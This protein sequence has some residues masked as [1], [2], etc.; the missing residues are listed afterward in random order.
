MRMSMGRIA[1]MTIR[2]LYLAR[3]SLDHWAELIYWPVIDLLLWGLTTRWIESEHGDVPLFALIV[4]TGVVFW[5]IVWRASHEI[6][7]NLLQ[8][9]WSQ[10]LLNLFATPLSVWE[11]SASLVVLGLFKN[12]LTMIVGIATV[13]LLYRLNILVVGWMLLPFFFSLMASGW[14]VGFI[15]AGLIIYYGRRLQGLAWILGF[16]LAPF[17]AVYY[18]VSV[19][20]YWARPISACLPM[21]YVFEGMREIIRGGP[22]PI[23][24]LL[25]SFALNL[26]YVALAILFFNM[27]FEKSRTRGLGRIE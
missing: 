7:V 22:P 16:V 4:L 2:H 19:L 12:V 6:S 13:W 26:F 24:F 25:I 9:I 18:P 14:F 3:R 27:M 17:S 5:K 11:W 1:A 20:P 23:N 10:N 15:S 8:E 21:T